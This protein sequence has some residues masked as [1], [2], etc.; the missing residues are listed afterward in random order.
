MHSR[1]IYLD[2][3]MYTVEQA[4]LFSRPGSLAEVC[5]LVFPQHHFQHQVGAEAF[6][7]Y[8]AAHSLLLL[9]PPPAFGLKMVLVVSAMAPFVALAH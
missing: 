8:R 6:K 9:G 4:S 1:I 2:W 7:E 3:A 5:W